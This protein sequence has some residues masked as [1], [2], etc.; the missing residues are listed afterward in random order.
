[1]ADYMSEE[2]Q[3]PQVLSKRKKLSENQW[4]DSDVRYF[5]LYVATGGMFIQRLP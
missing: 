4:T 5:I 2:E 3:S 1:M